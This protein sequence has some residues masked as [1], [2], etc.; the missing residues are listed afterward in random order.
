VMSAGQGVNREKGRAGDEARDEIAADL[1]WVVWSWVRWRMEQRFLEQSES[2]PRESADPESLAPPEMF[3]EQRDGER[4]PDVRDRVGHGL[5]VAID[6]VDES[7]SPEDGERRAK[8][9]W[10][11]VGWARSRGRGGEKQDG[12][13]KYSRCEPGLACPSVLPA[14]WVDNLVRAPGL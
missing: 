5:I 12:D 13:G 10:E 11:A 1:G 3:A 6:E 14:P 8:L 4:E 2:Y 7:S 9:R